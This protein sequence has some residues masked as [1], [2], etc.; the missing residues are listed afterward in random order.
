MMRKTPLLPVANSTLEFTAGAVD[1]TLKL[2]KDLTV[3]AL[4]LT[5][6]VLKAFNF[7][8]FDKM[9][10]LVHALEVAAQTVKGSSEI[11]GNAMQ[12]A[13]D[14]T[15]QAFKQAIDSVNIA[16]QFV[17]SSVYDNKVTA[18][19]LGSSLNSRLSFSDIQLSIRKDDQDISVSQCYADFKA[20]GC[21]EIIVYLPGLFCDE[22]VWT[23]PVLRD[24]QTS[25]DQVY[26]AD[27]FLS[28]GFFSIIVRYNNGK[29]VPENGKELYELLSSF[30]TQDEKVKLHVI[31]YS[32]GGLLLR[33]ALYHA[34]REV[35]DWLFRGRFKKLILIS[36]PDGGSY[37]EKI[38]YFL[39]HGLLISPPVLLKI[40]G[41]IATMRSDGI[42]DLSHGA[43]TRD[44]VP[45]FNWHL[46]RY[47]RSQYKGELDGSDVYQFYSV[48]YETETPNPIEKFFGDG[49]VELGSLS[50]LKERYFKDQPS[51][52]KRVFEIKGENHFSVLDSKFLQEKIEKILLEE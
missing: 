21:K 45:F 25:K 8:P 49:V 33:S 40:I 38:G 10:G 52:E 23:R 3:Q 1:N 46:V 31:A 39:G 42:K 6:S 30:L 41:F 22:Y 34:E 48:L 11:T 17:I 9:G 26:M 44:K 2:S 47:F 20:S 14:K 15:E 51:P 27:H 36:S 19:I 35:N 12:L 32:L 28:K 16:D 50:Y 29:P 13:I 5:A 18:S 37:L 4:E 24:Q 7:F 43:I